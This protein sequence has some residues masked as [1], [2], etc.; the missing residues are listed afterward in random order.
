M[1]IKTHAMTVLSDVLNAL[2]SGPITERYPFERH[3]PPANLRGRLHFTP[4]GCTGCALCVKDCPSEAIHLITIDKA[5]KRFV[6][7]YH[8]D[9]CTFCGQCVTNCRFDCL[10]LAHDEWE[11]AS[12]S[13]EPFTSY[14]GDESDVTKFLA[15]GDR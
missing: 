10:E 15:R 1:T 7:E 13:R 4:N 2:H 3:D 11:L 6:M 12:T 8:A 14:Y 9:R 5:A